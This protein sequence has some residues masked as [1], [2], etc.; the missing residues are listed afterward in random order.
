MTSPP[1]SGDNP[2]VADDTAR[3]NSG[4][5]RDP[6]QPQA[7]DDAGARDGAKDDATGT[8]QEKDARAFDH[9]GRT[10]GPG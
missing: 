8:R 1:A 6:A 7:S 2:S 9:P 4:E 5:G 3:G 10:V